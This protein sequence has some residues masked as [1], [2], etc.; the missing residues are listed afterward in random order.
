MSLLHKYNVFQSIYERESIPSNLIGASVM[1]T[2]LEADEYGLNQK[3]K[4][5]LSL[6]LVPDYFKL[7]EPPKHYNIKIVPQDNWGYSIDLTGSSS[8]D[9][10]L[11]SQFK[12]KTRSI[13]RRYVRRLETCFPITYRL[14]YGDMDQTDYE[15]VFDALHNMIKARF[16]QRNE[17]H[18]E[19]WRWMELKKNIYNQILQRQASLFVIYDDTIPIEISLN[20]HLGPVLFSSVSSYDMDYA[21]FGLGHVEIYK[22]LEWC[23]NNGYKL[24]EMGVGGMDY[25]QKWSNHIYRFNHWIMIPKKSPLIKLIGMMEHYRVVTK[26]Y[27]KSKKV[28]DLRDF[29]IGRVSTES[30]ENNV[31]QESYGFKTLESP[32]S[33]NDLVPCG[34]AE[35]NQI[36]YKKTL[37]D[38]L[39]QEESPRKNIEIYKM[40][41]SKGQYYVKV[42]SRW[43]IIHP[44]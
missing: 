7:N 41:L 11:E 17:T 28:N 42:K 19:M 30:K 3:G 16:D 39:Y 14:Y 36:G 15:R 32:P 34:I 33:E 35:C 4:A 31:P 21:K 1:G 37:N 23:I 40:D 26:E 29:L 22:Q 10:Y 2:P 38:L 20:Y 9:Q 5:V 43:F 44:I 12:S 13:I 6:R 8:I 25:K 24:F 27:L 18:K